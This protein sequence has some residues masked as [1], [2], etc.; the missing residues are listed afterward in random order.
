MRGDEQRYRIAERI[1]RLN[2]L[3]FDVDEVELIDDPGGG[4]RLQLHD[5]G[6]RARP[7]PAACC[8]P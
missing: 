5:P 6:G 1:R 2:E 8:S 3:G 4:S 7:P